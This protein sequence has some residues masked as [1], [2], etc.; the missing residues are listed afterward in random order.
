MIG[1]EW[2]GVVEFVVVWLCAY[3][4]LEMLGK[5]RG[6]GVV[7]GVLFVGVVVALLGNVSEVYSRDLARLHVILTGLVWVV[8]AVGIAVFLPE[9][10]HALVR[11]GESTLEAMDP[12]L[13]RGTRSDTAA[14]VSEAADTLSRQQMGAII[15]L[16]RG[17]N[18]SALAAGGVPIDAVL[19]P[20]LLESIFWPSTP[21]HDLAVVIRADR[22][23][24]ANVELPLPAPG[25]VPDSLGSRHRAAVGATLDT[26]ALVVVVS[27]QTGA[28]RLAERG[29]LGEPVPRDRLRGLL[30]AALAAGSDNPMTPKFVGAATSARPPEVP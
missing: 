3:A 30:A 10:R 6:A 21:L 1:L 18:L 19:T 24:A 14:A 4:A 16:E 5:S 11:V 23:A 7:K 29:L 27:E 25:T 13:R 22:I 2:T 17:T 8:A 20:R 26:D 9:I 15:V 12:A 28:I